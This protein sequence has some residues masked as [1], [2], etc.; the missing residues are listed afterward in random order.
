MLKLFK[1]EWILIGSQC[2]YFSSTRQNH[3]ESDSV[4]SFLCV[5]VIVWMW[6]LCAVLLYLE[7]FFFRLNFWFI[8]E[9]WILIDF[10]FTKDTKIWSSTT[11]FNIDNN[12]CVLSTK[13]NILEH[14]E[15]FHNITVF[16]LLYFWSNK[17]KLGEHK[18]LFKNIKKIFPTPN[19]WTEV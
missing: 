7:G 6:T 12:K 1:A 4:I 14:I 19:L 8:I 10:F 17:C 13:S 2:F 18:R 15:I 16:F 9:S 11:V 5:I 3:S